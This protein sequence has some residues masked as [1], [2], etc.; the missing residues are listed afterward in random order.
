MDWS[1]LEMKI[2][3]LIGIITVLQNNKKVTAP[4]L[5]KKFE[6]SRRTINRDIEDIC[7]AGIPIVT[8]QGNEGGISIME[9]FKLDTTVFTTDELEAILVGLKSF[10]SVS[11]H[12]ASH[13]L[14]NKISPNRPTVMS[15]ADSI[16]I[17]LSSH[18]K[19]SLAPKIAQLREAIQQKRVV[20]FHY[21]YNKGEDD[22]RIEPYQIV[23]QWSS[24][25]IFGFCLKKQEFRLYKL[26]RLW[27]LQ[28]TE[29]E[30]IPREIPAEC[31]DF[32]RHIP[33]HYE[34]TAVFDPSEK[35][36]L[37]EEYSFGCFRELEDGRL[38]F[39][40]GF[41]NLEVAVSW[42]LGF[43]DRVEMLEPIEMRSLM[44]GEIQKMLKRYQS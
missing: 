9:G 6:V 22:K 15:L 26:N 19:D 43:G 14:I 32:N 16:S 21:Y 34:I 28:T 5:A 38:L 37:I 3:R 44:K 29:E 23:F 1:E 42:F 36:R 39:K 20:T 25:Y 17:D 10:D 11:T 30:F 27:D 18:Y 13:R 33:D 41:T 8:T 31:L 40:R 24:W 2:D 35:Y 7:K 12:S 4:Y